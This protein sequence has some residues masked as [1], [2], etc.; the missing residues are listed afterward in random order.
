MLRTLLVAPFVAA[1]LHL[2][3]RWFIRSRA[4]VSWPSFIFV[5]L[6]AGQVFGWRF[7]Q[8]NANVRRD[9]RGMMKS[10]GV[11]LSTAG[12]LVEVIQD[13]CVPLISPKAAAAG[14]ATRS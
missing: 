3:L 10:A 5:V 11:D 6:V 1:L 9:A 13:L 4:F 12:G 8:L 7:L 2:P 14:R